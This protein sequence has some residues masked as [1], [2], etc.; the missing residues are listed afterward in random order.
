[1]FQIRSIFQVSLMSTA[2]IGLFILCESILEFTKHDPRFDVYAKDATHFK[3]AGFGGSLF[4]MV[5]AYCFSAL[6]LAAL[7]A[8]LLPCT[9]RNVAL[10][11]NPAFYKYCGFL[12]IVHLLQAV[13]SGLVYFE[14]N[15]DGLCIL[16]FGTFLLVTVF[17]P[18]LYSTFLSPFS[19]PHNQRFCSLI[20]PRFVTTEILLV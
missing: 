9:K 7:F 8:A 16:S 11:S 14:M 4:S 1:M 10:P 20:R 13:G 6:Y 15:P 19:K 18:L 2:I 17:T 3:L 5:T 12:L